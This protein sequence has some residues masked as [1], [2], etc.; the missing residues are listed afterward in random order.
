MASLGSLTAVEL[1]IEGVAGHA[2]PTLSELTPLHKR[3]F[4]LLGLQ[5]HPAPRL[6]PPESA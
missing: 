5:P 1:R 3:A 2:V 4:K 6:S